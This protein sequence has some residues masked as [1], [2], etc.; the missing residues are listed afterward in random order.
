[1]NAK[2]SITS[3]MAVSFPM[4]LTKRRTEREALIACPIFHV[5]PVYDASAAMESLTIHDI[6]IN[7]SITEVQ[8][9]LRPEYLTKFSSA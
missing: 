6:S 1:M 5:H 4:V 2:H 7:E 8:R 3:L 9:I